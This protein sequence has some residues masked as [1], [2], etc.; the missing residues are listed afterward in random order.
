MLRFETRKFVL[1]ITFDSQSR[2][3]KNKATFLLRPGML[4]FA[5][6][7]ALDWRNG[8]ITSK[9]IKPKSFNISRV[10]GELLR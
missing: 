10:Q 3:D 2:N 7:L 6:C 8:D 4:L 1:Q 9:Y 5:T